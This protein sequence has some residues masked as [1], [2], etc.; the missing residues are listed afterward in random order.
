MILWAYF[1]RP[2]GKSF[3]FALQRRYVLFPYSVTQLGYRQSLQGVSSWDGS[4]GDINGAFAISD[5]ELAVAFN[6]DGTTWQPLT[7]EHG[8]LRA[9]DHGRQPP[10]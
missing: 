3:K 7:R 9:K 4:H 6:Y 1:R 5:N 8:C 10:P 2:F